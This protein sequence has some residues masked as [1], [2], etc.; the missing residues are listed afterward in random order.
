[1][2]QRY[3]HLMYIHRSGIQFEVSKKSVYILEKSRLELMVI[4]DYL[5]IISVVVMN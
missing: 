3:A 1:M 2:V 5:N 4:G